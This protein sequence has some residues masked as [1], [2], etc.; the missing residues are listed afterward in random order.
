VFFTDF[1]RL[2]F[3][4]TMNIKV[5][6]LTNSLAAF[7]TVNSNVFFNIV[8]NQFELIDTGG[9]PIPSGTS[10]GQIPYWNGTG[11]SYTAAISANKQLLT[12]DSGANIPYWQDINTGITDGNIA[13]WD[14]VTK[15]VKYSAYVRV[16]EGSSRV[17]INPNTGGNCPK[18][19]ILGGTQNAINMQFAN[20]VFSFAYFTQASIQLQVKNSGNTSSGA[21]L[22][23]NGDSLNLSAGV[24]NGGYFLTGTTDL[25]S[26]RNNA[27]TNGIYNTPN[28]ISINNATIELFGIANGANTPK[29]TQIGNFLQISENANAALPVVT[30]FSFGG[31][32][33]AAT[34]SIVISFNGNKYQ[35]NALAL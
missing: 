14:A 25:Q 12:H 22:Y 26:M 11:F 29:L 7:P 30:G 19:I 18:I 15:Q 4:K 13:I 33:I 6:L 1:T 3:I 9:G 10:A 27:G 17:D 23:M 21:V 20:T 32:L 24:L 31:G 5:P 8:T 28:V 35:I 34:S 2:F 16:N